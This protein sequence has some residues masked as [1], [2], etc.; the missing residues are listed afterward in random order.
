MN[1]SEF[2]RELLDRRCDGAV[3]ELS[4]SGPVTTPRPSLGPQSASG[5]GEATWPRDCV[6]RPYSRVWLGSSRSERPM[7]TCTNAGQAPARTA[8]PLSVVENQVG[9]RPRLDERATIY[10]ELWL[11]FASL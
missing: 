10:C 9:G 8:A 6:Y 11:K 4:I 7:N 1:N 3:L 2:A 5:S